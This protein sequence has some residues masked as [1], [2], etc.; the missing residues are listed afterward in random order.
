M[1]DCGPGTRHTRTETWNVTPSRFCSCV[2]AAIAWLSVAVVLSPS[3]ALCQTERD[4]EPAEPATR[5]E[6]LKRQ[7]EARLDQVEPYQ[8][9]RLERFLTNLENEQTIENLFEV[10]SPSSGGYY[11]T[12][13]NITTGAGLTLGTGYN[14]SARLGRQVELSVRGAVSLRRYWMGEVEVALPRLAGGRAFA[15]VL[16]RRSDYPEEDYYGPG[17]NSRLQDRV[18][19]RHL[20]TL[21]ETTGGVRL[22]RWLSLGGGVS[23]INPSIGSGKDSKYPSLE[24]VFSDIEAPGLSQQPIFVRSRLFGELDF[25]SPVENPRTGGRYLVAFDYFAD[26]EFNR[27]SFER[28]EIDARQYLSFLRGRRVLAFRGLAS[29]SDPNFG[30]TVPFYLQQWLGGS[31][32]LRGFRDFRLRDRHLML[33]QAEYRWELFPALDAVLFY[34]AGKV[35][36]NRQEIN[37][38]DFESNWGTGFRIGTDNGVYFR[39]DWA[40]GSRDGSHLMLKFSNVF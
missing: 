15:S 38:K 35:A 11:F 22:S 6:L 2:V 26:T 32:T 21:V 23:Y 19:F 4:E 34:D 13:G 29:F 36:S 40:L 10:P 27:Y 7:R 33:L 25:A 31:H 24:Q 37:F 5:Q 28:W 16:A 39:L 20:Q 12:L 1:I 18:N 30:H 17:P 8:A 9:G 14:S 3:V